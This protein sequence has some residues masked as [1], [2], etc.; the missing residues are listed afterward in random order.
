VFILTTIQFKID[1]NKKYAVM[2]EAWKKHITFSALMRQMV[3]LF[4]IDSDF[5]E[6]VLN[7]DPKTYWKG[8]F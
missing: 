1:E 2:H 7:Y 8:V 3:D 5:H 6:K 4:L